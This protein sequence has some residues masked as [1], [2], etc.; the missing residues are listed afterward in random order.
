MPVLNANENLGVQMITNAQIIVLEMLVAYLLE[1]T[2]TTLKDNGQAV[3]LQPL[4][5]SVAQSATHFFDST[6][7]LSSC[8]GPEVLP[9]V[10]IKRP[11]CFRGKQAINPVQAQVTDMVRS[12]RIT[13][14][15]ENAFV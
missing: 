2:I 7:H 5:K 12:V 9:F 1:H 15:L 8:E 14:I 13:T 11:F 4:N 6:Q 3:Q 10:E